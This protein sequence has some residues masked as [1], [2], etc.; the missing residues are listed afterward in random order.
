MDQYSFEVKYS[1]KVTH[2][3]W[4]HRQI[5][6]EAC[7]WS[8][9]KNPV[10]DYKHPYSFVGQITL[11]WHPKGADKHLWTQ[12]WTQPVILAY[13]EVRDNSPTDINRMAMLRLSAAFDALINNF[14]VFIGDIGIVRSDP[15]TPLV[16]AFESLDTSMII[17]DRLG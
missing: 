4:Q 15:L 1:D 2:L 9:F 3:N 13:D 11:L 12:G 14:P 8:G 6:A 16:A 5:L 7:Q 10:A 17:A